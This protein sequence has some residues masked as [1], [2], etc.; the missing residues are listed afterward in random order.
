M[1][2]T[3]ISDFRKDAKKYFD[4]VVDDYD[5]LVIT[6]SDG[7][8]GV[9]VSLDSY[10]SMTETQHLLSSPANRRNLLKSL[11]EARTGKTVKKTLSEL[12]KYE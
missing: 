3:S 1:N 2:V 9:L 10:N 6:R 11:E 5:P 8:T 12:K 7:K 4:R